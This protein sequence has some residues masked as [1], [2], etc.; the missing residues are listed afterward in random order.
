MAE[1]MLIGA[2]RQQTD[3]ERKETRH[4]LRSQHG[5]LPPLAW[6]SDHASHS[7]DHATLL[8]RRALGQR[9]PSTSTYISIGSRTV[10]LAFAFSVSGWART[11]SS[12]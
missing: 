3:P 4:R 9:P 1:E 11:A 5:D 8:P 10:C 12:F 2:W 7:P 6:L